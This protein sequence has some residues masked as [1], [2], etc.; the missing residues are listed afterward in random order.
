MTKIKM[1]EHALKRLRERWP[2]ANSLDDRFLTELLLSQIE[3]ADVVNDAYDTAGGR[4]YPISLQ[5][6]D[7]YAVVKD[8]AVKTVM[9]TRY[10]QEVDE[11]RNGR[12]ET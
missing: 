9:P 10:C 7:G 12:K 3:Q 6:E 4:Y 5:G 2:S 1:S 8:G 11:V